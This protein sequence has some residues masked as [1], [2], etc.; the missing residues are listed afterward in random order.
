MADYERR[1]LEIALEFGCLS[2]AKRSN[3]SEGS[4]EPKKYAQVIESGGGS[5]TSFSTQIT[6]YYDIYI[7]QK[8]TNFEARRIRN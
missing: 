4:S 6:C 3:F 2:F 7:V 1:E 5:P 8:M